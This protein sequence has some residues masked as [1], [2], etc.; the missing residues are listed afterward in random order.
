[1]PRDD[2][3]VAGSRKVEAAFSEKYQESD[4]DERSASEEARLNSPE[5]FQQLAGPFF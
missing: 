4:R 1:M 5:S 2:S 3:R